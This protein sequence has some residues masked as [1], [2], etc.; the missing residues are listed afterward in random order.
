ML[1]DNTDEKKEANSGGMGSDHDHR[2][3]SLRGAE[4]DHGVEHDQGVDSNHSHDVDHLSTP[5]LFEHVQDQ[6]T[7][8]VPTGGLYLTKENPHGKHLEIPQILEKQD[9]TPAFGSIK[10]LTGQITRFMVIEVAVFFVALILFGWLA[11]QIK[12]GATAKGRLAN[13]LE[14]LVLFIRDNVARPSIG[15]AEAD[16]FVPFLLSLFFFILGCNLMGLVPFM[17]SPTGA[18]AVTSVM[19]ILT[20][21]VVC[22]VGIR[23]FGVVGFAL[24]QVPQMD[25]PFGMGYLLK[26]L[27]LAIELFGLCLKHFVLSVR[28][29]ANMMAGHIILAVFLAFIAESSGTSLQL[30]VIPAASGGYVAI[31]FLELFV[32]FLQAYIFTFLAAL[33]IGSASHQH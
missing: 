24:A 5:H 13:L 23:K 12:G 15:K 31:M 22:G 19:A 25:L 28:L 10:P 3:D 29:L 32:A 27:M 33:F 9:Y 20:F 21:G 26:P 30:I 11:K 8:H 17:G 16:K 2:S 1:L 6:T 18:W 7:F 14:V 4:H